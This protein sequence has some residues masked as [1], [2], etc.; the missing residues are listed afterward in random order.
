MRCHL[1]SR[2]GGIELRPMDMTAERCASGATRDAYAQ[3]I[4]FLLADDARPHISICAMRYA[5]IAS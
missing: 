5:D 2:S 4:I 1:F 3:D